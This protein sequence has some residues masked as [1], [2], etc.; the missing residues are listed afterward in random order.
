MFI[1][2]DKKAY[3]KYELYEKINSFEEDLSTIKKS[4][5]NIFASINILNTLIKNLKAENE[6]LRQD[7]DVLTKMTAG[8]LGESSNCELFVVKSYRNDPII[9]K[10]GKVASRDNMDSVYIHWDKGEKVSVEVNS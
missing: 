3:N 5:S 6:A 1:K 4:E 8:S 7:I 9:I 2:K 10:D